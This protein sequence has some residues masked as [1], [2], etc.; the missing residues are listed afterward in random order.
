MKAWRRPTRAANHRGRFDAGRT[1]RSTFGRCPQSS[2]RRGPVVGPYLPR[3]GMPRI[4]GLRR[5]D[6]STAAVGQLFRWPVLAG[7]GRDVSIYV[8]LSQ[9][10]SSRRSVRMSLITNG[11][12]PDVV[13]AMMPPYHLSP[14]L[15]AATLAAFR[16]PQPASVGNERGEVIVTINPKQLSGPC[17][18][19]RPWVAASGPDGCVPVSAARSKSGKGGPLRHRDTEKDAGALCGARR[20]DDRTKRHRWPLLCVSVPP[21]WKSLLAMPQVPAAAGLAV[22]GGKAGLAQSST[23][24]TQLSATFERAT[25]RRPAGPAGETAPEATSALPCGIAPLDG[26]LGVCGRGVCG[27]GVCGPGAR[28]PDTCDLG[29][30]REIGAAK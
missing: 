21:R 17:R 9:A 6:A 16:R 1:Y 4:P 7:A 13:R 26:G 10:Y 8:Y 29:G 25:R 20:G 23:N 3:K 14:D 12:T 2:R 11:I 24:P 15:L 27:L 19:S 18:A 5:P 30:E 22:S 28:H